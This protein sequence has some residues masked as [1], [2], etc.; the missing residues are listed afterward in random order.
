MLSPF[1]RS[2]IQKFIL[3]YPKRIQEIMGQKSAILFKAQ[4][5]SEIGLEETVLPLWQP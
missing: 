3:S 4:I 1:A 2:A 5:L